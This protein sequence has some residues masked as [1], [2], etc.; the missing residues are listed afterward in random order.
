MCI[1]I[2]MDSDR[3]GQMRKGKM[4]SLITEKHC[5][6]AWQTSGFILAAISEG[7]WDALTTSHYKTKQNL[8]NVMPCR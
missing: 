8:V 6:S 7:L 5:Q 1:S 3:T 4:K 2:L